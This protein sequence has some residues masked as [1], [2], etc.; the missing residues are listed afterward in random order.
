[1]VPIIPFLCLWA[2]AFLVRVVT[3]F[4]AKRKS[5]RSDRAR[6]PTAD[7]ESAGGAQEHTSP[8]NQEPTRS[9]RVHDPTAD[10]GSA[11]S[12]Q[13]HT[14]LAN[15]EST[16]SGRVRDPTANRGSSGSTRGRA[17]LDNKKGHTW[18][19]SIVLGTI[20]ILL[21]IEPVW[22]VVSFDRLLS[23]KDVRTSA[24]EWID[25]HVPEQTMMVIE[26]YGPPVSTDTFTV[27]RVRHVIE[28]DL[29]WYLQQK[30]TLFVVSEGAHERFFR[31]P[32]KYATQVNQYQDLFD[33]LTLVQQFEGPMV[34]REGYHIMV[35]QADH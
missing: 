31:E 17:S 18:T 30:Y 26:E 12:A 32:E 27:M 7:R 28:H 23:H 21:L 19:K 3:H 15:Q 25:T 24:L 16:C 22:A 33:R 29:N 2:A 8:G 5:T 10:H 13:G 9:D 34:G 14:S 6:D 35:Y 11:G 1:M 20:T 4:F